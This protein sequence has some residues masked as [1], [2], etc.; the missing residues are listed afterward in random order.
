MHGDGARG[1]RFIDGRR[2]RWGSVARRLS[3]SAKRWGLIGWSRAT[4]DAGHPAA[5]GIH[6][7]RLME[8]YERKGRDVFGGGARA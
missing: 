4:N 7:K 2:N 6:G 1:S 5:Y 3:S 8:N